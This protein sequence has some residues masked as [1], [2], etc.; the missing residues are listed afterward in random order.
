MPNQT[1]PSP[2]LG[3]SQYVAFPD[4]GQ[5]HEIIDGVHTVNPAPNTYHQAISRRIQFQLYSAIEL[6]RLGEVIN[7]PVDVQLSPHDIL[8]PDLV[9]VLVQNRIITP[10]KVK[11]VPDLVV[12]ILSPSSIEHDGVLKRRLYES[13]GVPEYWIVDPF[14]HTLLQLTLSADRYQ[15]QTHSDSVTT[16]FPPHVTVDLR[17]VW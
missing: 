4:D 14:E 15:E 11:G 10:T 8:Q 2:K 7:S 6:H 17:A 9:V 1:S 12:E 5:R 16:T 13:V 3:Y